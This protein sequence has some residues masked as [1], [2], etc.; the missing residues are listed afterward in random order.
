MPFYV[1]LIKLLKYISSLT[2]FN[3]YVLLNLCLI[4]I[5]DTIISDDE[6]L[7]EPIEWSIWQNLLLFILITSWCSEVLISS[8][9]GNYVG[10]DKRVWAALY[11]S[12]WLVQLYIMFSLLALTLFAIVPFYFELQSC[13]AVWISFWNWYNRVFLWKAL[14]IHFSL[15]IFAYLI[16]VN[17]RWLT[18]SKTLI[19]MCFIIILLGILIYVNILVIMFLYFTNPIT[20]NLNL[21]ID[22]TQ[23][24]NG[25]NKWGWG[26]PTKDHF[27]YHTTPSIF[28][29][30]YDFCYA[31][32]CM[33]IQLF[34]TFSYVLL[35]VQICIIFRKFYTTKS[36]TY[37]MLTY[38]ANII[39]IYFYYTASIYIFSI[40]SFFM[41]MIRNRQDFLFM[42]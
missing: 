23:L 32:S 19:I 8:T 4:F 11:K 6:P 30:K 25:P 17:S 3:S 9:Y 12:Y 38:Y 28:W 34:F 10:R 5:I 14:S 40:V 15:L 39:R 42:L 22:Y 29:Y 33:I 24:S 35:F 2:K 26:A 31:S 16:Q 18:Y 41:I 37:T 27:S 36:I 13:T 20:Y 7:F 21:N 1:I